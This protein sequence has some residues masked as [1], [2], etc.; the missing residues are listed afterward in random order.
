M[1]VQDTLVEDRIRNATTDT[2][3]VLEHTPVIT[4]G[5]RGPNG[6]VLAPPAV[7]AREGID[8]VNTTRGG[9]VTYHGPGQV[10][11]YSIVHLPTLCRSVPD[12]VCG[13]QRTAITALAAVGV[14]AFS[15]PEHV[16]IWTDWGKIGAIGVAVRHGVTLHGL[17]VNLQPNLDHFSLIDACG[18]SHLGITSAEAIL[19]RT[20]DVRDFK[21]CMADAFVAEFGFVPSETDWSLPTRT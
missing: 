9:L 5:R 2:L 8:L 14:Q 21:H 3:L 16:G 18:L 7:L 13:L 15:A 12:Y 6:G 1:S 4:V 17:A 10:V 20:V 19:G 11:A